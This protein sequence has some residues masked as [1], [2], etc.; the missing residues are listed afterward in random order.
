MWETVSSRK[1]FTLIELMV[2]V[3]I[4]G[5]LA[6]VALPAY[7]DY[8][9]RAKT[10]EAIVIVS[11]LKPEIISYYRAKG[12][13]PENNLQA[14]V[15]KKEHILGNYV[16]GVAVENGALHITMGNKVPEYIAGKQL[17]L[18]PIIVKESPDSPISWVCGGDPAPEGM[19]AVGENKT[20]LENKF[21]P[22]ACRA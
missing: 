15:P 10:A 5:I 4:I 9:I 2:V 8:T 13:F 1:G 12:R 21:L 17:S 22:S 3:A 19:V 18:R 14:G 11:E 16:K 6:A 20:T 7:Q